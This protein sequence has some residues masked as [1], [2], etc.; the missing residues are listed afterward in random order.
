LHQI[1]ENRWQGKPNAPGIKQRVE[2][3]ERK[4]KTILL[5]EVGWKPIKLPAVEEAFFSWLPL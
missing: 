5:N 4:A 1:D 2:I 3:T